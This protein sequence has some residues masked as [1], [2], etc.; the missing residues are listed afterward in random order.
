[1]DIDYIKDAL[2]YDPESGIFVWKKRPE[3]HFQNARGCWQWNGKYPGTIAGTV[4]KPNK[5]YGYTR[6]KINISGSVVYAHRLAWIWCNG[7]IPD[8]LYV[9]HIDGNA[10]NNAINNLRLVS[11]AE[12]HRNRGVPANNTSGAVGI[13]KV[14]NKWSARIKVHGKEKFLGNFQTFEEAVLARKRAAR[15]L[16]FTERHYTE[17]ALRTGAV[18]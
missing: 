2:D 3:N 4:F 15:E 5:K 12:N 7:P 13:R 14:G 9:D 18:G 8:G 16:G 6:I 17:R 11:H 1:M 10:E